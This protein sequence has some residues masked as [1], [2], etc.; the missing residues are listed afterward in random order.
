VFTVLPHCLNYV[1]APGGRLLLRMYLPR[2]LFPPLPARV[3]GSTSPSFSASAPLFRGPSE[4]WLFVMPALTSAGESR[5][6]F[7]S[8]GSRFFLCSGSSPRRVPVDFG[9]LLCSPPSLC[10]F[11]LARHPSSPFSQRPGS[12]PVLNRDGDFFVST[13]RNRRFSPSPVLLS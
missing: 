3:F 11:P 12:S 1:P 2:S 8:L 10:L 6:F 9:I 4:I 5:N 7:S 13:D